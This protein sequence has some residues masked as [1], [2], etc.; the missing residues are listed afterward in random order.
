[1]NQEKFKKY[2]TLSLIGLAGLIVAPIIFLTIK[3]IVG[4]AIAG[5]LAMSI[6]TIAPAA[7]Q[8]FANM[9]FKTLEGVISYEPVLTLKTRAEERWT[10]LGT[11]RDLLEQQAATLEEFTKKAKGFIKQFPEEAADWTERVKQYE[12][13]FAYRVDLFK[14]AKG[15]TEKFMV[16]IDK[17]EGIYEMAVLDAKMSKSFGKARDFMSIFKEKT[18]FDA[19][20]K[21]NSKAIASLRMALVDE[22]FVSE[23]IKLQTEPTRAVNYNPSGSVNLGNILDITEISPE[24]IR[25]K[26]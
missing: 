2:A 17:A 14:K 18:A 22:N 21:A 23:Q 8:W 25:I 15:E 24:N 12:Q 10:E 3:G 6:M 7:S 11:Q 26:A 4:L 1:M 19:I 13:I 16:T 9:K 5:V 20:D